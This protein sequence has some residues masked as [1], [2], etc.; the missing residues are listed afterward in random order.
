MGKEGVKGCDGVDAK[1]S[2]GADSSFVM[3]GAL[4]YVPQYFPSL[5]QRGMTSLK[6][7]LP[8]HSDLYCLPALLPC[9]RS[10]ALQPSSAPINIQLI[11]SKEH[12]PIAQRCFSLFQ[13][14]S[15]V[16]HDLQCLPRSS[17]IVSNRTKHEWAQKHLFNAASG[18]LATPSYIT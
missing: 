7:K 9:E 14:C 15:R 6:R 13:N 2:G 16:M 8:Q 4:I 3:D 18:G 12:G 11:S 10:P 1:V 5:S 17:N